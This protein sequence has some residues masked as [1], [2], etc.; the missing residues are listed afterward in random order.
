MAMQVGKAYEP[1]CTKYRIYL[2]FYLY[3]CMCV[4]LDIYDVAKLERIENDDLKNTI[5]L[6][7]GHL[8]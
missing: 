3:I 5:M 6:S 4:Y 8:K 1:A 7:Y 2:Q